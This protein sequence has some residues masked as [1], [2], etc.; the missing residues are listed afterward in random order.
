MLFKKLFKTLVPEFWLLY[1]KN[2][3]TEKLQMLD[4]AVLG[5][6]WRHVSCSHFLKFW[7][8]GKY[9]VPLLSYLSCCLF[10][11]CYQ[12]EAIETAQ[13][14]PIRQF[15]V[16]HQ[17]FRDF[18]SGKTEVGST[19]DNGFDI[20]MKQQGAKSTNQEQ[21][22]RSK[23]RNEAKRTN[24]NNNSNNN[25]TDYFGT[26]IPY[27]VDI[28][29]SEWLISPTHST[30]KVAET[31]GQ[32]Q[33]YGK[34]WLKM[35]SCFCDRGMLELMWLF[36]GAISVASENQHCRRNVPLL[37]YYVMLQVL[38]GILALSILFIWIASTSLCPL[39]WVP[40]KKK[41]N[42]DNKKIWVKGC[43]MHGML[44]WNAMYMSQSLSGESTP[45]QLK[46]AENKIDV[47]DIHGHEHAIV[48][49]N[50]FTI[51][52]GDN[53]NDDDDDQNKDDRDINKSN[54]A[55]RPK[56]TITRKSLWCEMCGTALNNTSEKKELE[57]G[58][59]F[60]SY[61]ALSWPLTQPCPAC[62]QEDTL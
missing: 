16:R 21:P 31:L 61:C 33:R 2:A 43:S 19:C 10:V 28:M 4:I 52:N 24:N 32:D 35:V 20:E 59:E 47:R 57:C 9:L 18:L 62:L 38:L 54:V 15:Q 51:E 53:D 3:P 12:E 1:I 25:N 29:V 26:N 50:K 36:V 37:F 48:N 39:Q 55:T 34:F 46:T 23:L 40:K 44:L 14:Y 45:L 49:A 41:K 42:N 8:L 7:I 22:P 58:H 60:H 6:H 27:P 11:P 13:S 17:Q 56:Q 5:T 30:Q